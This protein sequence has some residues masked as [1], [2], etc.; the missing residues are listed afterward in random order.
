MVEV[1]GDYCPAP[2]QICDE[3]ISEKRDRCERFREKAHCVGKPEAKH[4]C[5]DRYEYPNEAGHH[6]TV[7]VTWDEA[8][9]VA[10]MKANGCV[11]P[12]SGRW[13]AKDLNTNPT[14]SATRVM[15]ARAI[16]ISPIFYRTTLHMTIRRP[17]PPKSR[18]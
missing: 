13:L 10:L 12:K 15:L 2:E 8:R 9:D 11:S 14:H 16:L 3:Y 6:P 4:F 18:A 1:D 5:I 7:S 17:E